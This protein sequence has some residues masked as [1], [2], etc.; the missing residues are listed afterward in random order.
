MRVEYSC[1]TDQKLYCSERKL[2]KKFGRDQAEEIMARLAEFASAESLDDIPRLPRH[3]RLH[4]L[5]GGQM[6]GLLSVD[7]IHTMRLLVRP[8]DP[9]PRKPSGDLEFARVIGIVIVGVKD[10]HR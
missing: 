6:N 1:S 4:V 8:C 7:L 3:P 9:V 5:S 10:T 2:I